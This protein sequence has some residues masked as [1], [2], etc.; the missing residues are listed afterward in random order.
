MLYILHEYVLRKVG[1]KS[2]KLNGIQWHC[3]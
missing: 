3:S 2:P 1:Y